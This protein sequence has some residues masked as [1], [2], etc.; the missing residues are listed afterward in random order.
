MKKAEEN[1]EMR[2]EYRREDLG[3]GGRGKYYDAYM[4][5]HDLVLL[6]PEVVKAF[7]S[8]EAVNEALM[9]LI[10]IAQASTGR[11]RP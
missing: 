8:E 7:P 10:K 4:E 6:K 2:P 11:T 5:G 1:D 9:S 3:K